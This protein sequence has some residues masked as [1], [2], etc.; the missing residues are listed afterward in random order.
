[1]FHGGDEALQA[2]CGGFESHWLHQNYHTISDSMIE[3]YAPLAQ[4]VEAPVLETAQ[5]R[6]DSYEGYHYGAAS[7]LATAP[8]LNPDEPFG[9]LGVRLDPRSA[10][11]PV[12]QLVEATGSNLV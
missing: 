1:M 4:L 3:V 11:S 5:C 10:N 9:A 6:F 12:A 7:R 8:G 2:A